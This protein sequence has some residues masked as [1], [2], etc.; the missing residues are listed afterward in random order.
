[1][2][3]ILQISFLLIS[4]VLLREITGDGRNMEEKFQFAER[5]KKVKSSARK[6]YKGNKIIM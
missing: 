1:M 4:V 2:T 5:T 6:E 3:M